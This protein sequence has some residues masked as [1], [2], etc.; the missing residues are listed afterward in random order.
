MFLLGISSQ[1]GPDLGFDGKQH[2]E[3]SCVLIGVR[4]FAAQSDSTSQQLYGAVVTDPFYRVSTEARN[5]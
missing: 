1:E 5:G 2:K 3:S 4:H